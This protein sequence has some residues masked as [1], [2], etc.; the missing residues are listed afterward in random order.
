MTRHLGAAALGVLL[1]LPGCQRHMPPNIILYVV[2]TLRADALGCYGN[3]AVQTPAMDRLAREGMRFGHA[4]AN[5]SWT[6]ASMGSLLTGEYPTSHGAVGRSGVL[7]R[8]AATLA[9][10]LR[11]A[12]YYTVGV[13]ANPNIGSPFGFAEGF[14][15]FTELYTAHG[16]L[17]GPQELIA[18]ADRVV[19][20]AVGWLRARRAAPFF[21][22][23][24][25]IDPHAPYTPPAPFD[26]RY[27]PDYTGPVDGTLPSLYALDARKQEPPAR[28]IRHLRALYHGE[29]SFNDAHLGRLLAE[30]DALHLAADTLVVL[31]SDHGEEFYE[32][33]GRDHGHSLYEELIHVP[34]LLRWPHH[35][36]PAAE[37][38]GT[39]QLVD[40]YP[41]LLRLAG[42]AV[43][44]S[45]GRDLTDILLGRGAGG[46]PPMMFAEERL[47]RHDLRAVIL[48]RKLILDASR[49]DPLSFD[50]SRDPGEHDPLPG[51]PAQDL[52]LAMTNLQRANRPPSTREAR[53]VRATEL[54]ES[55]RHAMEALGYGDPAHPTPP[56]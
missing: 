42:A 43:P 49:P 37:Y 6:R 15:T 2:D 39:V 41:T 53:A 21:L 35:I 28:D 19:D 26:T 32:H 13:I 3:S 20:A 45:A 7:R 18:T 11:R 4:Y 14:D 46:V 8:G 31:T 1:L 24:F 29:V 23:I 33:G 36:A 5:A 47:D 54:P 12:G 40:L 10:R 56:H 52:I 34:L 38:P 55:V 22:L 30:L 51:L 50:L 48:D 44:P 17:V 27:D 25:S 16:G 9:S